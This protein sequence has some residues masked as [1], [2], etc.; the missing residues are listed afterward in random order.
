MPSTPEP[1]AIIPEKFIHLTWI[2]QNGSV[3][4]DNLDCSA[5]PDDER[6]VARAEELYR[7]LHDSRRGLEVTVEVGTS[8]VIA[9][10]GDW[11]A[12][13]VEVTVVATF[14]GET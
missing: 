2:A 13:P 10:N 12:A 7:R 3:Q 4:Y 5:E 8:E 6:I 9:V 1:G 11:W 14:G